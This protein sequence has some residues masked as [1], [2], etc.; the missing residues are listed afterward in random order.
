MSQ[1]LPVGGFQSKNNMPKFNE[2]FTR[3][4]DED[5]DKG[6]IL[7]ADLEYPKNLHSFHNNLPFL[8]ERMKIKKCSGSEKKNSLFNLRNQQSDICKII[9]SLK[10]HSNQN[11][12]F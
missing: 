6:Y 12:N 3:N 11:I 1:K 9:Y 4:Y 8:P 10:I 7:Q 5:S 2:K